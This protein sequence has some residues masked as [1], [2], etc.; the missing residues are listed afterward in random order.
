MALR[1][2]SLDITP[3]LHGLQGDRVLGVAL[4]PGASLALL[5]RHNF[6][7]TPFRSPSGRH[8][9]PDSVV[10]SDTLTVEMLVVLLLHDDGT[11]PLLLGVALVV[12]HGGAVLVQQV[13]TLLLV[14]NLLEL[15]LDRMALLL[16]D[17]VALGLSLVLHV[18]LLHVPALGRRSTRTI[19][20]LMMRLVVRLVMRL[21]VQR[22]TAGDKDS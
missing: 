7:K 1:N 21:N 3:V 6:T 18:R 15:P 14:D 11:L 20:I 5:V 9:V 2:R 12:V 4:P 8:C 22:S 13:L 17:S 19:F 10:L 16:V